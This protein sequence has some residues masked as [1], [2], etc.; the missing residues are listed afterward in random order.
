MHHLVR[1]PGIVGNAIIDYI[2]PGA[3]NPPTA[4]AQSVKPPSHTVPAAATGSTTTR[5][6]RK[7]A[8]PPGTWVTGRRTDRT[9]SSATKNAGE[10]VDEAERPA[11]K[12]KSGEGSSSV[13][14]TAFTSTQP[15]TA[16]A[17]PTQATNQRPYTARPSTTATVPSGA[18]ADEPI[19]PAKPAEQGDR[20]K[21]KRK[22]GAAAT[23]A[24]GPSNYTQSATT[25]S[26]PQARATQAQATP[27]AGS[28]STPMNATS[29]SG[30]SRRTYG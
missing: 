23:Q 14:V 1:Q 11:K 21:K 15:T 25:S 8:P 24:A 20:P 17:P 4:T 16:S 5:P 3:T 19:T 6:K 2:A 26:T 30:E 10:Q 28:S 13:P 29:Q 22:S 18:A 27:A 12:R 7:S 9:G